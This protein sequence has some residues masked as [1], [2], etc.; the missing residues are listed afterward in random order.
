MTSLLKID[1]LTKKYDEET[2]ALS[3]IDL[4]FTDDEFVVIIGPSGSGKSTFIRCV[5]QL[6]DPTEGSIVFDGDEMVGMSTSGLRN[7]RTKIGMVF[8]DYN[9]IQRSNVLKNV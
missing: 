6:V 2:T 8:Q 5:N 4:D 9:L 3:N 7:T 1:G